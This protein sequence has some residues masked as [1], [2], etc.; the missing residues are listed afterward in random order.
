M[1]ELGSVMRENAF[2][3]VE[4]KANRAIDYTKVREEHSGQREKSEP[5]TTISRK[6]KLV[7]VNEDY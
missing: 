6:V 1:I 7:S 4:S 5:E 2:A 3:L